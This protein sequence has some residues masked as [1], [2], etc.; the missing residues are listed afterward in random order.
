MAPILSIKTVVLLETTLATRKSN[1]MTSRLA[2]G[3]TCILATAILVLGS[4]CMRTRL[5][6][7]THN[8][9]GLAVAET[10]RA[11]DLPSVNY[12]E[13]SSIVHFEIKQTAGS[14]LEVERGAQI[15]SARL[16]EITRLA[17]ENS[18]IAKA[19]DKEVRQLQCGC[20]DFP[21]CLKRILHLQKEHE[22][23]ASSGQAA[24][25]YL[26]LA[27]VYLQYELL[28]Q[29]TDELED[30]ARIVR[31]LKESELPID[32]DERT[33]HRKQNQLEER[34]VELLYGQKRL[35]NGLELLLDLQTQAGPIWTDWQVTESG[36]TV[37]L[38]T[39]LATAWANRKDLLALALLTECCDADLLELIRSSARSLH[40]LLGL[41]LT[42]KRL[43]QSA[44]RF[45]KEQNQEACCRAQQIQEVLDARKK[46]IEAEIAELVYSIQ[47]RNRIIAIKKET[48]RSLKASIKSAEAA[49]ELKPLDLETHLQNKA[50]VL[51]TRSEMIHELV[52]MEIEKAKLRTAQGLPA[53]GN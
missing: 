16:D 24:E 29:L 44:R 23:N 38:D 39:A 19:I 7:Q 2:V 6:R 52:Q 9:P 1:K 48:I 46:L 3:V 53:A 42:K 50:N 36:P 10:S 25:L 15:R 51:Q 28:Q 13:R 37:E 30:A 27:E 21:E 17:G 47:R 5:A 22:Q 20:N 18:T 49:A 26:Q 32:F 45:R 11:N 41:A 35:T 12:D 40:P 31:K 14:A 4:G 8:E 33:L 34:A 43:L